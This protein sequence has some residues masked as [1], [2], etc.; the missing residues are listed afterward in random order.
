V[1]RAPGGGSRAGVVAAGAA[2]NAGLV[3]ILATVIAFWRL[4][5]ACPTN[6]ALAILPFLAF[7]T[8]WTWSAVDAPAIN[9][10]LVVV[11]HAVI[12]GG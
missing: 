7:K 6:E 2:I 10:R 5:L 11:L 1:G 8:V 12:M 4:A 9:A 3:A